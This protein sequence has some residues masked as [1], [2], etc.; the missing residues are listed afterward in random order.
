MFRILRNIAYMIFVVMAVAC[1]NEQDFVPEPIDDNDPITFFA[2]V[3]QEEQSQTRAGAIPLNNDFVVYGYKVTYGY[4]GAGDIVQT[5]FPGYNVHYAPA[6]AGTAPDNTSNYS[7]LGGESVNHVTQ[8]M[9]Y[10][11]YGTDEY[12]FW[13]Y[14]DGITANDDGTVLTIPGLV[15]SVTEPTGLPLYSQLYHRSPVT[16]DVV[17]LQFKH[18]YAK[19]RILFYTSEEMIGDDLIKLTDITFG[20]GENSIATSGSM[21][22]TYPKEGTNTFP[23]TTTEV[24]TVT[25]TAQQANLSFKP[26]TLDA[27]HGTASS[28]AVAAIPA[29]GTQ[30]WY[31]ALPV[32]DPASDS[33]PAGSFTLSLNIDDDPKTAVVPATYMQWKPNTSYTYIFKIT[34]AGKKIEFYDVKIDPWHYGG[35]QD[36]TWTNW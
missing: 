30:D 11:D 17:Q 20:G 6:S 3:L 9:K 29:L 10:W 27:T 1:R 28:N 21:T 15:L 14:T 12:H 23:C 4:Y 16:S 18:P 33:F 24:I 13:G 19:V 35:S 2:P 26:T 32:S 7:Y 5:V 25:P 22:V 8:T 31:Y 36:E 34:E